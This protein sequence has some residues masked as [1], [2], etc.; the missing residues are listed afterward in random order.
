MRHRSLRVSVSLVLLG[1]ASALLLAALPTRSS[2]W[3]G[4]SAL[5]ALPLAW[6]ALRV[7]W[8]EVL[9]ARRVQAAERAATAS[10]YRRLCTTTAAEHAAVTT[11]I[12]E[13]LAMAHLS[14]RELEGLLTQYCGRAERAEARVHR[15][16]E[17]L[18]A[19]GSEAIEDLVAWDRRAAAAPVRHVSPAP[20]REQA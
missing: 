2:L 8:S 5:M 12:T 14:Q 3:Q 11:A 9:V 13:R 15:L 17:A 7:M 20:L 1:V 6:A 16:E 4:A 10:A 18:A 19:R